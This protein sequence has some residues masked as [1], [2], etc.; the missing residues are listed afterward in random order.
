MLL[1][2]EE[3]GQNLGGMALVGQAVPHRHAC[4]FGQLLNGLLLEAAVL[5]AVEHATQ[6]AGGV[7]HALLYANLAAGGSQIG[8]MRPLV[9]RANLK[10]AACAGGG[11]LKNQGDVLALQGRLFG[12]GVFGA[13]QV[14]GQIQQIVQFFRAEV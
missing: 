14:A 10:G 5:D 6:H 2:G 4:V 8:D 12:A 9:L 11:L 13:L 1:H 7:G 3:V